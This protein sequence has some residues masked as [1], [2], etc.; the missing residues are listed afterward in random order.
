MRAEKGTKFDMDPFSATTSA[1]HAVA[2]AAAETVL[3][4]WPT[5]SSEDCQS[6]GKVAFVMSILLAIG[7]LVSY[8][9]Q[10]LFPPS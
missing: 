3:D 9:P 6:A 7:M 5:A 8:L 2:T 10:V 4:P 1:V